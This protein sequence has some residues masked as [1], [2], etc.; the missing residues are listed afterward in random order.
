M[1][2]TARATWLAASWRNCTSPSE[3]CPGVVLATA[4]V[5]MLVPR[6]TRG[7]IDV[8]SDAIPVGHVVR[9]ILALRGEVVPQQGLLVW[10][11]WPTWLS[12]G[13]ISSPTAK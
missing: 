1:F 13:A 6:A 5:P 3:Y 4:S 10:N 12:P 9:R 7:T 8:R 2:A 11:T